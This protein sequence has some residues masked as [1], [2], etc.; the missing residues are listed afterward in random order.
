[1]RLNATGD[2]LYTS[3]SGTSGGAVTRYKI[4]AGP[5]TRD[6]QSAVYPDHA[7]GLKVWF[8]SDGRMVGDSGGVF[9]TGS[10]LST[11]FQYTGILSGYAQYLPAVSVAHSPARHQFVSVGPNASTQGNSATD[12]NLFLHG[13]K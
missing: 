2:A 11:D 10:T 6:Y 1:F 8:T 13:D 3:N 9:R 7:L 12:T 4:A 5:M